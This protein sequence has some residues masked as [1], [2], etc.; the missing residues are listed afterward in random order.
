L[1]SEILRLNM[2]IKPTVG[3][4]LY[5]A[6]GIGNVK[7]HSISKAI[8]PF[9]ISAIVVLLLITYIPAI[10]TFLPNLRGVKEIVRKM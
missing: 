7:L 1:G 4:N 5:V 10:S 2:L 9:L 3:I 6:C 8:I